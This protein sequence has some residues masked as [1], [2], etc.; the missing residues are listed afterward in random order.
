MENLKLVKEQ[1]QQ[2]EDLE[3]QIEILEEKLHSAEEVNRSKSRFLSNMSHD[4]RT[5]MNAIMGMTSIGLSHIDEKSRVQDCL[6]KIHTASAHLMSLVNDVLDMSILDIS[7]D[8]KSTRLN[9]SHA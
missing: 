6:N 7:R 2:I 3:R 4:I 9:S 5:P 8:R 1:K